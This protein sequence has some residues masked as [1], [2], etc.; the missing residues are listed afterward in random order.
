M[1]TTTTNYGL[2]KP[3]LTDSADITQMNP[4]WDLLDSELFT[5]WSKNAETITEYANLDDFKNI[6]I[7]TYSYGAASTISNVPEIAQGTLFVLPRLLSSNSANKI[8]ILVTQNSNVYVRNLMDGTWQDWNKLY[9]SNDVMPIEK[10]GTGATYPEAA[11]KNLK[12][13]IQT[14]QSLTDIGLTVGSETIEAI[15]TTMPANSELIC[16]TTADNADIYPNGKLGLLRV[17]KSDIGRVK[18]EWTLKDNGTVY[19]GIYSSSN[20]TPWTGWHKMMDEKPPFIELMP[21]SN[22]DTGGYVDFHY[23]ASTEDYTSRIIEDALG[24]LRIIAANGVLV[25]SIDP[26]VKSIRNIYAGTSDMTAGSS[27][28]DTGAIYLVYE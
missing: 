14:Y 5:K 1:S 21:V 26:T 22:L 25:P 27:T 20:T 15:A 13:N 10:G 16:S 28:L 7:Y 4:N 23:G 19:V 2:I 8:Q 9:N 12:V 3:A 24:H 11:R 18:F 17:T 6:G